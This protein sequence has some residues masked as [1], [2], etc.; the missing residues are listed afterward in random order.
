MFQ[1]VCVSQTLS[2]ERP[3]TTPAPRYRTLVAFVF[4]VACSGDVAPLASSSGG[5]VADEVVPPPGVPDRGDDPAVVAIDVGGRMLC[6]GTLVAPDVVLTTYR[7]VAGAAAR[8]Q[9]PPGGPMVNAGLA[10]SSIRILVG[11]Q[12]A[13]AQ[14]RARGRDVVAS[15][16]NAPCAVDV[17]LV[18]LDTPIDEIMPLSVRP[19]GAAK[20]DRLRTVGFARI[21]SGSALQKLARDHLAVIDATE[22]ELRLSQACADAP[23]GPAIDEST[24]E[25][26]GI[27]SHPGGAS[28]AGA[29]AFDVYARADAA[30]ALIGEA[31]ARSVATASSVK[32]RKKTKKGPID[33]GANCARGLDCAAGVC[34][35]ERSQEYC[36]RTCGPHDRCPAHFR[37]QKCTGASWVCVEG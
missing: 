33:M 32:G 7:C 30:L 22:T 2:D 34:V 21:S 27:D 25:I 13:T 11:D 10:T 9:C 28:C 29:N 4:L 1:R 35:T 15:A 16:G 26:V 20:G 12:T 31:L 19:T 8:M 3:M 24:G 36:S 14:E 5:P 37:C 17:A 23:G 18:L 6:S